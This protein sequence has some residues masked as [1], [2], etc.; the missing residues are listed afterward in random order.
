MGGH[1]GR[2][3]VVVDRSLIVPR[4][5]NFMVLLRSYRILNVSSKCIV[6]GARIGIVSRT[7][8]SHSLEWEGLRRRLVLGS[9]RMQSVSKYNM[10]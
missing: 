3:T 5:V 1:S 2:V 6:L 10:M 7:S 4:K 8:P 9:G